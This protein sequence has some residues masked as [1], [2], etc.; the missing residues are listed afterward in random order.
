[1]SSVLSGP[2]GGL[3]GMRW[4]GERAGTAKLIGF[5]MGGTSTDVSL[6]DGELPQRFEHTIA[7]VRLTQPMLDV[8]TIAAGGGSILTFRDGRFAVGPASAG[9]QPGP[10]C[11][12]RGGPL[13]LTD[14]QVLLGHLR[15]DTLPAVFGEDGRSAID[16]Q[17]V[18]SAFAELA[19]RVSAQSAHGCTAEMVAESFL[20]VGV[21]SMANAIRQVSARQGLDAGDFTLFCF[22][23]AAGQ[24]ACR[25]AR[26][27]GMRR[28]L[29]HPLASVLSAFGI[30][31]ADRLAVRRASLRQPLDSGG[32]A[33]ARAALALLESQAREEL[34]AFGPGPGR[35]R[36]ALLLEVRAGDSDVTLSVPLGGL[37]EV[38]ERFHAEHLKRFGFAAHSLEVVI[39]AL[40][41]EA[42]LASLDAARLI[43]PSP[44]SHASLP[45]SARAWFDGWREVPL[46]SMGELRGTLA[47]PALIVEPHSTVVLESGWRASLLAGGELL[48]ESA[49]WTAEVRAAAAADPARIE[50]SNN[51]FMHIAEQ[52]GEV[53]KATA[54]SVN[55]RER[56]D[57]SC[58]LFDSRGG[59]VANAPHM[60][61]H[62]G[63]MG[64]S[65]R[66]VI[67]ARGAQLEPGDAWLLNSPYHGGTH[68]PDMTVVT[69]VF[70]GGGERVDFFVA[71]RAHHADI[72]GMTPGSMPPF[73]RDIEEEGALFECFHLVRGETLEERELRAALAAGRWPARSP[74]Q[75]LADLR[76]QLAANA[77]GIAEVRRAVE[78]YG[79]ASLHERM[80]EVQD[81]AALSV[82]NAIGE[83]LSGEFRYEMDGGQV[84]AVRIDIDRVTR[85]AR[86]DFTGT[87]AQGAH[88]FNAPRAVCLAAVLYVFRTLIERPIPLN[89]GCLEPLEIVIPPGSMLDPRPPAAVAAGNVET[90]QC[91]VDALYGALGILAA[92]QGT[93]NNLT[94]GDEQ[95]QYYETIA[96]GAGA[97]PDFDG[98]DAVHTHMTNSRLTDPEIL[99]AKFPVLVREFAIRRGSGGRGR[100]HGGDGVVRRIEFR[101]PFSGALLANHRR[102]APF[103]LAGGRPG[104]PGEAHIRRASGARE[105]LGATARFDVAPG[106]EL[107]ILTPGGGGFGKAD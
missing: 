97:G 58:A 15:P 39:E 43:M 53:L 77:R 63:S 22:G 26:A 5:D 81:N 20:E 38:R 47:G 44:R 9:A 34:S 36:V 55:I 46:V 21:E 33:A 84:I 13:T 50:I 4:A 42:R 83:Q 99:E 70:I 64:A 91:I 51:L 92:S 88:N 23:G 41:A 35:A 94:F 76:A 12:R 71:S 2:A 73:S 29:I 10:A 67:G 56:L 87:S 75:N 7:G 16:P 96:G 103:G 95:L 6:I 105:T 86:V 14:V 98:C 66:A 106:D 78:R 30:G 19:S 72:G 107:A 102:V 32:L 11:Y 62:L 49:P 24:H 82:R 79:L 17:V 28:V 101:A 59:L 40:R 45:R 100:H 69:P 80:R 54:Q 93:M 18:A 61:V 48:L 27:A 89:E 60:P 85:R 52:M 57:Y 65:V 90:S 37:A 74:E 1:M 31:V 104:A 25:V 68:L 8:H 3:I